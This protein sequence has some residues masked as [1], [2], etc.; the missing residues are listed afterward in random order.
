MKS[1]RSFLLACLLLLLSGNLLSQTDLKSLDKVYGLD[2]L[3]YNGVKY[4]YFLPPGTGGHQYLQSPD[5]FTGSVTI[6]EETFDGI[7]LNYDI[8]NQVLLL[9]YADDKGAFNIIEIS[10]SWLK[11]FQL[12]NKYF[13][14]LDLGD[15]L[16]FYQFLGEGKIKL[17]YYWFKNLNLDV[18]SSGN[19]TFTPS[20]RSSFILKDNRLMPYRNKRGFIDIMGKEHKKEIKKHIRKHKI[21]LK[22]ATDEEMT[23]LIDYIGNL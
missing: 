22:K 13:K 7:T 16:K 19:F 3:L 4:I 20:F 5:Y 23:E 9:R 1:I 6:K 10:K 8:Y 15:G 14:Y 2:P 18:G 21:K 11:E 17:V 12:G